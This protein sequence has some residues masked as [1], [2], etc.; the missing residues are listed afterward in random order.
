MGTLINGRGVLEDFTEIPGFVLNNDHEEPPEENHRISIED[1]RKMIF[2]DEEEWNNIYNPR[3][4]SIEALNYIEIKKRGNGSVK[5]TYKSFSDTEEGPYYDSLGIH[6]CVWK[7]DNCINNFICEQVPNS[8]NIQF[9][10]YKEGIYC[11]ICHRK[12]ECTEF[13][14]SKINRNKR[15]RDII[16]LS[17]PV[18]YPSNPVTEYVPQEKNTSSTI[19]NWVKLMIKVKHT[20]YNDKIVYPINKYESILLWP[21]QMTYYQKFRYSNPEYKDSEIFLKSDME[22]FREDYAFIE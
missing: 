8:K 1:Y 21:W 19:P 2:T 18:I 4:C 9:A 3:R 12:K 20:L 14:W 6:V 11:A 10:D 7:A 17:T 15:P 13:N 22:N 16:K 5:K